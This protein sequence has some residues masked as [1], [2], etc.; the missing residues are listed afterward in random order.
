MRPWF[1]DFV[2]VL[3]NQKVRI[4]TEEVTIRVNHCFVAFTGL[5]FIG[6]DLSRGFS[7]VSN[8]TNCRCLDE[9]CRSGKMLRHSR[10]HVKH[11]S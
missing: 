10:M 11:S 7:T 3:H 4:I 9:M 6:I 2:V 5:L 1:Q 8:L